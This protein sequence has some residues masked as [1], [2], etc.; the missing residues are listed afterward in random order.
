MKTIR[1][2]RSSTKG[3]T[4]TAD[5]PQSDGEL[6]STIGISSALETAASPTDSAKAPS[7]RWQFLLDMERWGVL[8]GLGVC[9]LV[10]SILRPDTF[11]TGLN[12]RTLLISE[13]VLAIVS[14]GLMIPAA[15]GHYDLSIGYNAGFTGMVVAWLSV[16]GH[17]SPYLAL[18]V[19]VLTGTLIGAVNGFVVVKFKMSSFIATL[20][21]GIILSGLTL[22][23]S[24]GMVIFNVPHPIITLGQGSVFKIEWPVYIALVIVV[25][26]MFMMKFQRFGRYVYATGGNEEAARLAGIR[27]DRIVITS[28]ILCGTL[29]G[30]AGILFMAYAGSADPSSGPDLLLPAFA[31]VFLG[32]TTIEPGRYNVIG[33]VL[34]LFFL[35]VL[36][37]G[38]QQIGAPT[39]VAPVFDGVALIAAVAVSIR[40]RRRVFS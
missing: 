5:Q 3:M 20:G 31:A 17:L 8:V 35:A 23:I 9:V 19:G 38:L 40:E 34:A 7:Q 29:G 39:W 36:V 33:T 21:S 18:L 28:M 30:I 6:Q 2:H 10:F 25:V 16:N 32:S 1:T 15:G 22:G 27:V 13:G 26:V 11:P 14:V 12:F 24:G 4:A 37:N